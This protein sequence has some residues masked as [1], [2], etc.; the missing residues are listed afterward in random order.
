MPDLLGFP[1]WD[2]SLRTDLQEET[3]LFFDSVVRGN[4]SA[5]D[6]L[7]A[8]YTFMNERIAKHYGVPNVYGPAFRRVTLTDENRRGILGQ[9]SILALT[10][11]ATRTSPVFRGKWILSNL[12]NTPPPPRRRRTCLRSRK[13]AARRSQ[14]QCVSGWKPIVPMPSARPATT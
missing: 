10:S 12:L 9:G 6:L 5:L 13:T 1:N 2:Y 8:D 7:N 14:S 4:R 11:V 3:H